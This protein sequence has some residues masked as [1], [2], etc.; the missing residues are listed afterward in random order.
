MTL[1]PFLVDNLSVKP[2]FFLSV[3]VFREQRSGAWV[4]QALEHDITAHGSSIEEAK[5]AF[6]RTVLG[7]FQLDGKYRR[8][9]LASLRPAPDAFWEVWERVATKQTELLLST[10]PS[11]PPAYIVNAITSETIPTIP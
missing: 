9:P 3:L 11:A 1:S 7:Y 5:T 6:E 2:H 4:A 8:E 10:D